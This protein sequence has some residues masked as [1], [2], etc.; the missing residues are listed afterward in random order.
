MAD[1]INPRFPHKCVIT[2]TEKNSNPLEDGVATIIIYKGKCRSYPSNTVSD[3]GE[4]I[5][6]MRKLSLPAPQ[7]DWTEDN[8]PQVGDEVVIKRPTYIEKGRIIDVQD[9]NLGTILLWRK[10]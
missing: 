1:Y 8:I 4:V 5:T 9:G 6:S 7:Q 2:R 10:Y 3:K